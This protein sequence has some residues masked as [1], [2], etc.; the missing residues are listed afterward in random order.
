MRA[1]PDHVWRRVARIE[2]RAKQGGRCLWCLWP[3]TRDE[4]TADHLNPRSNGGTDN[5]NIAAACEDC[6]KARGSIPVSIFRRMA[7]GNLPAPT[8]EIRMIQMSRRLWKRT[9]LACRRIRRL[10]GLTA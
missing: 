4:T 1:I 2:A 9:D 3:I 6:N 5:D 7:N 10:V 8:F